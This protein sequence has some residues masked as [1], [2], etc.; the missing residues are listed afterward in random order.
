M[1]S[2]SD[3]P[4]TAAPA[5]ESDEL[6]RLRAELAEWRTRFARGEL[7]DSLQIGAIFVTEGGVGEQVLNDA[8]PFV[9][10]LFGAGRPHALHIHEGSCEVHLQV[11]VQCG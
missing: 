6:V 9:F 7:R 4:V 8:Q 10:E 11:I 5:T 3:Q 1:T 2:I